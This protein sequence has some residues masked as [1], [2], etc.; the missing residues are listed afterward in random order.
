[1]ALSLTPSLAS[2]V[3][4]PSPEDA[5]LSWL[6][7]IRWMTFVAYLVIL[8]SVVAFL[9][10]HIP[11]GPLLNT[12]LIGACSNLA[13]MI[14]ARGTRY[15]PSLLGGP[16]IVLDVL[17]LT[18]LLYFCGGYTNPFSMMYLAYVSLAAFLLNARWTWGVFITSLLSFSTLF[19]FHESVNE[20]GIQDHSLH[21]GG[22]SLH[23]H[24]MLVAFALAGSLIVFFITRMSRENELQAAKIDELSRKRESQRLLAGLATV[25]A[26]AAHELAT[27]LA[28]LTLIADELAVSN[29]DPEISA[30]VAA[31]RSQLARCCSI[32]HRMRGRHSELPGEYPAEIALD[33]LIQDISAELGLGSR[34]R[35][36]PLPV[37]SKPITTLRDSL[38]SSL[39]A[40]IKNAA[41]ASLPEQV[42][43]LAVRDTG[44]S[45]A[46]TVRDSGHGIPDAA[47][48]RLGEPFF[49]TKEPGEGMGLGLFL[50]NL[51]ATQIG[52]ELSI[53]STQGKGTEVLL[54][55]PK[56]LKVSV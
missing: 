55:V 6:I 30:E 19:F 51:F 43:T 17:L 14:L 7:T 4:D 44:D 25:T 1:M 21:Q 23:L 22:F 56:H 20:L 5:K 45:L 48:S 15:A 3:N 9:H 50:V 13:L 34:L 11:I 16:C 10:I 12:L 28:T 24:G 42:V 8:G 40:L 2:V 33:Q 26:G 53:S 54:I 38:R 18:V 32:L 36:E 52:G 39:A 41:Q 35:C 37:L 46:F 47:R 29:K 27:P 49:T 31:M